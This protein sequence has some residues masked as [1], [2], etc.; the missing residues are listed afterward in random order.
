MMLERMIA[1]LEDYAS[2]TRGATSDLNATV[3]VDTAP[4]PVET[5]LAA[6][7]NGEV[8]ANGAAAAPEGEAP[9]NGANGGTNGR[10]AHPAPEPDAPPASPRAQS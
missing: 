1:A 4:P 5:S 3:E 7:V 8:G 9:V 10:K 6:E 2:A